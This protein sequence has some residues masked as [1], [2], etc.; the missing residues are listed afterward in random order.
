MNPAPP[1]R[2]THRR[3]ETMPSGAQ[4]GNGGLGKDLRDI[5]CLEILQGQSD[6]KTEIVKEQVERVA[7]N[8]RCRG[9]ATRGGIGL[10]RGKLSGSNVA[11]I[12]TLAEQVNTKLG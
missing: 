4:R 3:Q 9:T 1:G 10:G 8:D 11:L 12:L 6:I 7:G 5:S 2:E